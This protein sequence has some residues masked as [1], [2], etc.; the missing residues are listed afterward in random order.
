MQAA[1]RRY[2]RVLQEISVEDGDARVAIEPG[3]GLSV[4]CDLKLPHLP[5]Q[6]WSG[7]VSPDRFLAVF[8]AARTYGVVDRL[9]PAILLG[10]LWLIPL[11]RGARLDRALALYRGRLINPTGL[12]YA[13]EF[14][15]HKILDLIGDMYPVAALIGRLAA[16]CSGHRHNWLLLKRLFET[17]G[18]YEYCSFDTPAA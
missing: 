6:H 5:L 17:P 10:R 8:Q 13:D 4:E 11:L 3:D 12:R 7:D 2:I 1:P 14:V 18:A 9:W 16:N 15:R